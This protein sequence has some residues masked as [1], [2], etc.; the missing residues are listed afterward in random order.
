MY[1]QRF[2][3]HRKPFQTVTK[4]QDFFASS[5]FGEL[6]PGVVHALQTDLGVAVLTGPA[7]VGKSVSLEQIQRH[8]AA[9]A[10]TLLL[11]GGS[12]KGSADL[13]YLLHR[14][15][16]KI[17]S[18]NGSD[19]K[20]SDIGRRYEVVER[21]ERVASFWGP[22]TILLDDAHLICGDVFAE[23]R[24]LL[25]E[26]HDGQR[27]ARLLIAGPLQLEEVL[28]DPGNSHFARKIRTHAFLQPLRSDES[29]HYLKH[30]FGLAGGDL[31]AAFEPNAL[32]LIAAASDGIPQ[33]LNLL[34]DESLMVCEETEKDV[35]T[36]DVV[37]E[38]LTRLQHLP[39]SWNVSMVSEDEDDDI[40]DSISAT[41]DQVCVDNAIEFGDFPSAPSISSSASAAS[42]EP[43][44]K[45]GVIEIGA[46]LSEFDGESRSAAPVT[47]TPFADSSVL[48]IG[49]E[50]S[51][52]PVQPEPETVATDV[53]EDDDED[54]GLELD[55][56]G[57]EVAVE[58][59]A[60]EFERLE[61]GQDEGTDLFQR[62]EQQAE[63]IANPEDT[64]LADFVDEEVGGEGPEQNEVVPVSAAIQN[65]QPWAPAGQWPVEPTGVDQTLS[66]A[67][68]SDVDELSFGEEVVETEQTVTDA[69]SVSQ[70]FDDSALESDIAGAVLDDVAEPV[71][72]RFTLAEFG[73]ESDSSACQNG[74]ASQT[75]F[76][77]QPLFN[78]APSWPPTVSGLAPLSQIPVSGLDDDYAE[79]LNDLG[80]L[81]DA[82]AERSTEIEESGQDVQA[83]Q[84][85][86]S[87]ETEMYGEL[88]TGAK[89]P[90]DT[91]A[92]LQHLIQEEQKLDETA[93]GADPSS[94]AA[95]S[96]H[97][98]EVLAPEAETSDVTSPAPLASPQ[99]F[100]MKQVDE[101]AGRN[102][103]EVGTE[104]KSDG[105]ESPSGMAPK[106]PQGHDPDV[107]AFQQIVEERDEW[108]EQQVL[109]A[110]I[111]NKEQ[112]QKQSL[113]TALRQARSHRQRVLTIGLKQAAGAETVSDE[114][115][116]EQSS[117][118]DGT[119]R[120]LTSDDQ[121]RPISLLMPEA[122]EVDR[123]VQSS[124]A[125]IVI[126]EE[127]VTN[128]GF[129]NLFTRLRRR[130]SQAS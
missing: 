87:A 114:P 40:D 70:S 72:D 67:D 76:H 2:G 82:T 86:E 107:V 33:C 23:L 90:E 34:A 125:E 11:R 55:K 18:E 73:A 68:A 44:A 120:Q 60:E 31:N 16:L 89:G 1:E 24:S 64:S 96:I 102:S 27:F 45:N 99:F 51:E 93:T 115:H 50:I 36:R 15:L 37:T 123:D 79:L 74:P 47:E 35:V 81:I 98:D 109:L 88:L 103:N 62:S 111:E 53:L 43:V 127:E 39:Y 9:K 117:D 17:Q 59:S 65:F 80:L 61:S 58:I 42:N 20:A 25:E 75:D 128:S 29:I 57:L 108:H 26:G 83:S 14:K 54:A 66:Q 46:S 5:S 7:G 49:G 8:L 106:P 118:V 110:D 4:E 28:A 22:L 121:D 13:L 12:L 85:L 6:L 126:V 10:Q 91:I 101:A 38:A 105:G 19:T 69:V 3:L 97:A 84:P 112:S 56:S 78:T 124:G 129:T 92:G 130:R 63:T 52:S 32:E 21:L 94:D 95:L 119:D 104:P 48:E 113:P 71:V 100:S 77:F 122:P 116:G 41:D 30:L